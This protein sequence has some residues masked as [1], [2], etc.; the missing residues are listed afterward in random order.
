M[1]LSENFSLNEFIYSETANSMGIAN[2]PS[3]NEILYIQKL[4]D[5]VL[6]PLRDQIQ[7]PIKIN[8]GFRCLRLNRA[9]KS[10]D[11]S[12]HRLG[13]AADIEV[14]GLSN[15]VLAK[16]I[17]NGDY[18]FDQLILEFWESEKGA[19]SG[20]VH[21]SYKNGNNRKEI[22]TINSKGTFIGLKE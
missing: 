16:V 11:T 7:K 20:W 12:Q 19:N 17:K 3:V 4:V 10:K 15:L 22:L 21:I 9:L 5:N 13:Q 1:K 8:S 14:P 18:D 2:I 6:Q